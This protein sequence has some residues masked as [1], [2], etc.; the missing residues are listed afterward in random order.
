VDEGAERLEVAVE[1]TEK[2]MEGLG[3]EG[4]G[5][6]VEVGEVLLVDAPRP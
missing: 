6:G 4:G 3:S 1:L 2:E 5:E